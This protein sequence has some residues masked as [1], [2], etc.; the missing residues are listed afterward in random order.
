M[1]MIINL[2]VD[3]EAFYHVDR[4]YQNQD[5][6]VLFGTGQQIRPEEL[7]DDALGRA[8]D[9]LYASGQLKKMFSS[10][11]LTSATTHN[12]PIVGL[13]VDTT[14]VFVYGSYEGEGNLDI[15]FGFSKSHR[16]DLKQ[17]LIGLTV[18]KDGLP[19]LGPI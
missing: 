14:S 16:P 13:Q 10:I 12:V 5:L 8:L 18:N 3:R 4:F 7:N 19:L 15:T 9:K 1:A 6:E 2:L 11:T 17:F